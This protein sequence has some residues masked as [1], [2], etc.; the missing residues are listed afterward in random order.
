[1]LRDKLLTLPNNPGCYLMKD[2]NNEVIY[3]GKAKNL[4]NRVNSYFHGQH[5]NKTTKLVSNIVDFEYI[6]TPSE[7]EAFILE[8][9]LIKKYKPRFNIMFMD[10][11]SYP[12]LRLTIEKNPTLKLVRDRKKIKNAKYFGPY[13]NAGYA[14]ELLN[15]LQQLFPLRKCNNMPS[16]VCLY[17]HLGSCLGYCENQIDSNEISKMT[18]G[19]VKFLNGDTK[20]ILDKTIEERDIFASNME[21][22]KAAEKQKLINAINHVTSDN[23]MQF[24]S[25]L[26]ED[27][28]AYSVDKGYISIVG[29]LYREGKLL[30]RHLLLQPLYDDE[31]ETFSSYLIQYY[32]SNP[33]PKQLLLPNIEA[34]S[35]LKE[36]F[37]CKVLFPIKG[38][39]KKLIEL[40]IETSKINLK[41]KFDII[42][43]DRNSFENA[44]NQLADLLDWPTDRIELFDN[45]HTSGSNAVA[46]QVVFVNGRAEKKS[47]RLYKL[48]NG[49]N[50]FA[51]MK[52]V[53]YR[54]LFNSLMH[55]T[56]LP[57][58]IIVDGGESQIKAAKE[59]VEQLQIEKVKILG[60]VK[61][62][63]HQTDNLMDDNYNIFPI[64]KQSDLFYLLTNMQDEVHRFAITYHKKLREK[65]QSKSVLDEIE[66]IGVKRKSLLL[67]KFGSI[68]KIKEATLEQLSQVLGPSIA[69]NVY[70]YFRKEQRDD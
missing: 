23:N 61:N 47:Y 63:K 22:E 41:Q 35:S 28:F 52:E 40:A 7:K 33:L 38:D 67:K 18:D 11:S 5:N 54:R 53:I 66:N 14:R 43:K 3:V 21:Y 13:P 65:Q 46:G 9:N 48:S 27:V 55:Q 49:N 26:S 10:D 16:K 6:V 1:M 8:Y 24:S 57:D 31:N 58:I 30:N 60:L 69:K 70:D 68:K 19:I 2:K 62:D 59:I 39:K 32:Q 64:D 56:V 42:S 37:D 12:Y 34:L 4:K 50:D 15:L 45:S 44:V 20:E 17:Y 51:N 25:S 36:L 29:L